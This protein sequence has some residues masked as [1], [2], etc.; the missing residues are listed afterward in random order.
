MTQRYRLK[1][2]KLQFC[3]LVDNPAQPNA[4]CLA[5][6]SASNTDEIT[7][8]AKFVKADDELGLAFFW[9]FTSTNPDGTDHY[10]LQGD[11]IDQNF[12][13]AA[14]E[15]A[16]DGGAVDEMHDGVPSGARTVFAMPMDPEIAKIYGLTT[17]QSGLMIA[18]KPTVEQMA[19][20]KDGSYT[21]VSIGGLGTREA[22]K[23]VSDT[24]VV[25]G[26]L[27]TD[28]VN[29]HQHKLC[30]YDDGSMWLDSAVMEGADDPHSHGVIFDNG[31]LTILAD[32]GHTHQ[33]AEGQPGLV[34][35]PADAMVVVAARAPGSPTRIAVQS[36][37][38]E[39]VS[40][41]KSTP[42]QPLPHKGITPEKS[43]MATE[44][45]KTIA[46]LT[47]KLSKAERIAKLSG[48]HKAHFDT[49]TNDDA[50]AFLAKS[51]T[52][53]DAL[54]AEFSK[55][56]DEA[57]KVIYVSKSTGDVYKAKD[58]SRLVE[59][60]KAMDKQAET[61]E[62]ADIRKRAAEVLGGMP[63]TDEAH[64]LIVRSLVK[65]GAKQEEIDAAFATLTGM[66]ASSTIGKRAPGAGEVDL[67]SGNPD[68][69]MVALEKGL[70]TFAKAQN[71]TK[72][73][74]TDGLNAFVQTTEGAALKRA[75]DE[76]LA[77]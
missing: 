17:K 58:D 49:L 9:A 39:L 51:N 13:K 4:K 3:S 14:M 44:Q 56:N 77:G 20:L 21:G 37:P 53:R 2:S 8:T 16:L 54:V 69:A 61:I 29:G 33:L 48:A 24:R 1:L 47:A 7:A 31:T 19:K 15:W 62:K 11:T 34:V 41:V 5:I 64:D 10:D 46:D 66:K 70:T 57:N 75:Y 68:D 67:Q 32:S 25:K 55:R 28:L 71:I 65:S 59:M 22:V 52:E 30:V 50:E 35:V 38:R 43:P 73:I 6:K 23:R 36:D 26:Q 12:I 60:A 45:D 42:S 74:W 63:G 76:S 40:P 18:I 72:N 27:Y